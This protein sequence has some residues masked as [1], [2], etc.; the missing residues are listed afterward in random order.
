MDR[1]LLQLVTYD[2]LVAVRGN[3]KRLPYL[4]SQ[5]VVSAYRASI[6]LKLPLACIMLI[7]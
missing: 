6:I 5:P 1:R 3:S 7:R 2:S 4:V